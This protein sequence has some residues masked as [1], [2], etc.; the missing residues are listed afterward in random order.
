M[1]FKLSPEKEIYKSNCRSGG[2]EGLAF[3]EKSR[4]YSKAGAQPRREG[5]EVRREAGEG[6]GD[7]L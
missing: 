5:G 2:G 7:G 4:K 3:S 6:T 1:T